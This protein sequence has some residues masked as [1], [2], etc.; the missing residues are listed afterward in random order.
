MEEETDLTVDFRGR[1]GGEKKGT[2]SG[3][4]MRANCRE[5]ER[6][7]RCF[8]L[9]LSSWKWEEA[10][11]DSPPYA[12]ARHYYSICFSSV[13]DSKLLQ[14][15]FFRPTFYSFHFCLRKVS[16]F[17]FPTHPFLAVSIKRKRGRP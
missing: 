15:Y 4:F 13:V 7:K 14:G 2:F 5:K 16:F 3:S 11:A 6:G 9:S 10:D 12:G 17:T 8:Y 1:G